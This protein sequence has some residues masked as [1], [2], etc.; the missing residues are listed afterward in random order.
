MGRQPPRPPPS[1]EEQ[2]SSCCWVPSLLLPANP[3]TE[4]Q[5]GSSSLYIP[6]GR[7]SRP[8]RASAWGPMAPKGQP[9]RVRREG[10][11]ARVISGV[12]GPPFPGLPKARENILVSLFGQVVYKT[13]QKLET[14]RLVQSDL[15]RLE[16]DKGL[17]KAAGE[18]TGRE[19][20]GSRIPVR[21]LPGLPVS[22][23]PARR[24]WLPR[25]FGFPLGCGCAEGAGAPSR[26]PNRVFVRPPAPQ[27]G[28]DGDVGSAAADGEP[29]PLPR[30]QLFSARAEQAPFQPRQ[31]AAEPQPLLFSLC[32][33]TLCTGFGCFQGGQAQGAGLRG[34]AAGMPPIA[35]LPTPQHPRLY[36][37]PGALPGSSQLENREKIIFKMN[38]MY[39]QTSLLEFLSLFCASAVF[40]PLA[41]S[42]SCS[43]SPPKPLSLFR[44]VP[45]KP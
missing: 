20:A 28:R 1:R 42:E 40:F 36:L 31:G 38:L 4:S 26:S 15:F 7:R 22:P 41:P 32:C 11:H 39:F 45:G 2:G 3:S 37:T 18:V 21:V 13:Q 33:P 35:P 9:S 25:D 43:V 34:E 30:V 17:L 8:P 10:G 16:G 44:D 27:Q 5:D 6:P 19:R 24:R 23:I 29:P 14:G 12:P